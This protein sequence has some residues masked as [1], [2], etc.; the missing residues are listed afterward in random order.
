M[1]R[2]RRR[3]RGV[4]GR[5]QASAFA[6]GE[7]RDGK[8]MQWEMISDQPFIENLS[9]KFG[10]QVRIAAGIETRFV[11]LIPGNVLRGVVTM[12]RVRGNID[13]YF[14]EASITADFL[15]WPVTIQMQLAP[16]RNGVVQ[17]A[18]M[19]SPFNAAD[20]E[21]NKIVWQRRYYPQAS[22]TIAGPLANRYYSSNYIHQEV[23]IKVKRRFDRAT[24]ALILVVEGEQTGLTEHVGQ[25]SLRA[26]FKSGDGL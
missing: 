20:Q 15:R 18:A 7:A 14:D 23:D 2:F 25:I 26:L 4:A 9:T 16:L 21:S 12:M 6:P 1:A 11:T 5:K 22:S 8:G 3:A 13:V 24:W 19:L 10:T 17:V